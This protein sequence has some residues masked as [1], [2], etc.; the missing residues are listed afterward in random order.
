MLVVQ[1]PRTDRN[2]EIH[3]STTQSP[4]FKQQRVPRFR[5]MRNI[6]VVL[7]E[8]LLDN[9]IV[10]NQSAEVTVCLAWPSLSGITAWRRFLLRS[11]RL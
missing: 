5:V 4:R 10:S 1:S 7:G 11:L 8:L 9:A 6:L 2:Y 3:I